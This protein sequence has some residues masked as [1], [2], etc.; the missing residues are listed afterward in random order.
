MADGSRVP[1]DQHE[2]SLL[3]KAVAKAAR[4]RTALSASL[5]SF[6]ES[7]S[8]KL[9]IDGTLYYLAPVRFMTKSRPDEQCHPAK[10]KGK[11]LYMCDE[12][13]RQ[14][15]DCHLFVFNSKFE[16]SGYLRIPINEER[17]TFCNAIPALGTGRKERNELLVTTQYFFIDGSATKNASDIG[18]GWK[19]MTSL[20]RVREEDGRV[21]M[22]QNSSCLLNPNNIDSVPEARRRLA[23]CEARTGGK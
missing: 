17:P 19:R 8:F 16:E 14:T 6:E 5:L 12:G 4:S 23:V 21:V 10:D 11:L 1:D 7:L 15:Q 13:Q 20:V 18:S 22:E 2:I 9:F 3:E